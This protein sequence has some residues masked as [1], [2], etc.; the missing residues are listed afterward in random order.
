MRRAV[1]VPAVLV[2]AHVLHAHRPADRLRHDR[3]GLR[4]V[5]VAASPEGAGAFVV[6]HPH[7][8][9]RHAE[10]A[11]QH[12]ARVV[13]V[14]RRRLDQRAVGTDIGQRA[15]RPER[16]VTLVRTEIGRRAH[17]R[18]ARK[19]LGDV[20]AVGDDGVGR[21]LRAHLGE[22]V[23]VARQCRAFLP[24]HLER[25]RGLDR[26]PLVLGDH[27]D[28]VALAHDAGGRDVLD[29]AL[30]DAQRLGAGAERALSAR[31]HHAAVQHVGDAQMMHELV[32]AAHLVR[33]V[34]ARRPRTDELVAMR[35]LLRRGA[36]ELDV[37][38]LVTEKIAVLHRAERA[39]AVDRHDAVVHHQAVDLH[40]EPARREQQQRPAR[41]RRRRAQLRTAALDRGAR[42]G[43]A[44]VR[45]HMGVEPGGRN[46]AHRQIELF[47]CD[48]QHAR[49]VALAELALAEID[50]GGVVGVDRDP[51]IDR[52]RIG[53]AGDVAAR[54]RRRP[55]E[56]R[57]G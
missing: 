46:L 34:D 43:G 8:L 14:L 48:L 57:R 38:R 55:A 17:M 15:V 50:G 40:A 24:R 18:R 3:G 7:L 22:Q 29:R 27:A 31:Q 53:R 26:V 5:L 11:R 6:L 41:F 56:R 25:L 20:A 42:A 12:V 36:G 44:L 54:G 9:G 10:H 47:G 52:V 23:G 19:A 32:A 37:E 28:E 2:P 4:G 1:V 39:F 16:Q 13:D 45:R 35:R 21:L 33:Q 30:V 49:G 51:G